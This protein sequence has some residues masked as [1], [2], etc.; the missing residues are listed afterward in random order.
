MQDFASVL[1]D[2]ANKLA[3][4]VDLSPQ[5][6][7]NAL[8]L[9]DERH[10]KVLGGLWKRSL[11]FN[12]LHTDSRADIDIRF[13]PKQV[14]DPVY[15]MFAQDAIKSDRRAYLYLLRAISGAGKTGQC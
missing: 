15:T 7:A 1:Q 3:E 4:G 13:M 5:K 6:I 2:E 9:V 11:A 12:P 10:S 14:E 8:T